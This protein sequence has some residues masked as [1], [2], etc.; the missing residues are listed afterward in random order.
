MLKA[1]AKPTL[2]HWNL[3]IRGTERRTNTVRRFHLCRC[4][5]WTEQW[6]KSRIGTRRRCERDKILQRGWWGRRRHGGRSRKSF[7]EIFRWRC[8]RIQIVAVLWC[9]CSDGSV[10]NKSIF[11]F[12]FHFQ[13]LLHHHNHRHLSILIFNP[14][15][16]TNFVFDIYHHHHHQ[17]SI[18]VLG[19]V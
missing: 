3:K 11:N 7:T 17:F 8:R 18:S 6:S 13:G 1:K 12:D 5:I 14:F 19:C 10:T 9:C 15:L 2:S 16:N 4:Q